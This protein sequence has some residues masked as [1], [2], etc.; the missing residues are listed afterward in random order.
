MDDDVI[1]AAH[2]TGPVATE[3]L[4]DFDPSLP[5]RFVDESIFDYFKRLRAESPVHYTPDSS[6]G[7]FWS[8][9][10][11]ADI[12]AVD[13]NH[14]VYSSDVKYGGISLLNA[15]PE[16]VLPMFIAQDEPRHQA[17]RKTVAS[18]MSPDSL[19]HLAHLIR[20]RAAGL[21][22]AVPLNET[23]DWVDTIAVELT[24][25]MLATLFDFPW[26]ERRKL[27]RW[28][29]IA[30]AVPGG[31]LID[32]IEQRRVELAGCFEYFL[33]LRKERGEAPP[34]GDIISILAHG[35]AT[36]DFDTMEYM[37]NVIMLMVGGN[38]TTRNSISG[39]VYALN[40][41]PAEYEKLRNDHSLIPNF[42]AEIVR[43]QTPISH[44]RRTALIDTELGGK[45]IKQG[46]KVVMWY[47]SGN[48]DETVFERPD[49][50]IV[51]RPNARQHMGFGFGIHRCFGLRLA[52]LQLRI[53]W[54]EILKRWRFIEVVGE[55]RRT[56]SNVVRG[57]DYLPV[58]IRG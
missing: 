48:R 54:E 3:D 55:P 53:V 4:S 35:A 32:S 51:D 38:D 11:H 56:F 27:T 26:E 17:Q 31:G 10:R 6:A 52:E 12:M 30:V 22:D 5:A 18:T 46:D 58:R 14:Q 37:G 20:E 16:M 57:Y 21:L 34:R 47:A 1:A 7:P 24:T 43:W 36:R 33:N 25:Q 23:F 28:S 44:Q 13:M 45:K 19:V 41:F 40:K 29:N 8:L 50:I 9:T 2:R 39:S 42:V 15:D 49:E